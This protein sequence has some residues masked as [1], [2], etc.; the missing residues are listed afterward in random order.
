M[1]FAI[2]TKVPVERTQNEIR[3]L[4]GKYKADSFAFMEERDRAMIAFQLSGRKI[5]F[6]LPLPARVDNAGT[7]DKNRREKVCRSKWRALLLCIK[8]KLESVEQNI[9][10]FEEAFLAHVIMPNGQTV[11]EQLRE[12]IALEYK[13]PTGIPLLSGPR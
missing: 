12:P 10:S 8:A 9:E 3:T 4:L 5:K 13:N 7:T 11:Y 2:D 1:A 6:T